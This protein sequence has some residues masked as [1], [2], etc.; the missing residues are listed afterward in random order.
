MRIVWLTFFVCVLCHAQSTARVDQLVKE[1]TRAKLGTQEYIDAMPDD[2]IS[3]KPAPEIR[4]FAGQMLHIA[5]TQY[6]FGSIVAGKE[7]PFDASKGKDLEKTPELSKTELRRLVLDSYDYMIA[8]V[9]GPNDAWLDES[10]S[11][12]KSRMPRYLLLAKALEHHAHHRGQTT[13]YLRLKGIT[14]PSERLF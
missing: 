3:F 9:K 5:S 12:F 7:N 6:M 1:W 2:T 13:I 11:F 8:A 14:P 4:S 10:V